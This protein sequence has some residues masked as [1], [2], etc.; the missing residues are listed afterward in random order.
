MSA[1]FCSSSPC[2]AIVGAASITPKPAGGPTTP[3]AASS[4][5]TAW[6]RSRGVALA[7]AV[8]R[9]HRVGVARFGEALPPVAEREVGVPGA[10]DPRSDFLANLLGAEVSHVT[11]VTK[12]GLPEW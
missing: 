3:C 9:Q 7:A 5:F 8:L 4:M 1:V 11:Q 6:A 12:R 10:L 2:I